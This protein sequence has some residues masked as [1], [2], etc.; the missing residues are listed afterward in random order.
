LSRSGPTTITR[1]SGAWARTA[2]AARSSSVR[3]PTRNPGLSAPPILWAAPPARITASRGGGPLR[4][5]VAPRWCAPVW[6]SALDTDHLAQVCDDLHQVGLCFDDRLQVLVGTGDLVHDPDVLTAF[7]ATGLGEQVPARERLAGLGPAHT[8]ARPV[9]SGVVGGRVAQSTHDV[10]TRG[11]TARDDPQVAPARADGPLTGD[12]DVHALVGLLGHVVVVAGDPLHE[13]G[14]G[15]LFGQ[16]P[17][18]QCH[19]DLAVAACVC[20]GPEEVAPVGVHLGGSCN[21]DRQVPVGQVLVVRQL[22]GPGD[23]VVG[24]LLADVSGAGVQYQPHDA[25]TV[26]THFEEVVAT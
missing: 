4:A 14:A 8:S 20:L 23:V 3:P 22:L 19:H 21:E 26:Q 18:G 12:Q 25:V 13:I 7:H 16:C 5:L 6:C 10:D 9:R 2:S 1:A 24:Q 17:A 11:H 15:D